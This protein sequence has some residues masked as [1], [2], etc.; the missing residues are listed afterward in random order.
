MVHPLTGMHFNFNAIKYDF[1]L[2]QSINKPLVRADIESFI[3]QVDCLSSIVH[4]EL[5]LSSFVREGFRVWYVLDMESEADANRWITNL[6]VFE[7]DQSVPAAFEGQIESAGHVVIVG[8]TERKYRI[9]INTAE[10]LER[11]DVGNLNILPRSL[12]R[13]QREALLEQMK[14]K[15]RLRQNPQHVV[16]IDVDAYVDDPVEVAPRD[17][18]SRSIAAVETGL[19]RAFAK[20]E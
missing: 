4:E 18:V 11:L 10:R 15:S 9:E 12:P 7:I 1:S 3:D 6:G 16:A 13:K 5:E 14:G 19:P 17:F 20:Q 2:D 8:T